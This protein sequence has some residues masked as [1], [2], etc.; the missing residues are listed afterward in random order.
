[1]LMDAFVTAVARS[2]GRFSA[3]MSNYQFRVRR[4]SEPWND[5]LLLR[6]PSLV[7][8]RT[9]AFQLIA[10]LTGQ[11]ADSP[12]L[13]SDWYV[14]VSGDDELLK[15][16]VHIITTDAPSVIGSPSLTTV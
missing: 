14:E 11:V 10:Y 12:S 15:F 2:A 7:A 8:A 16:T 5:P 3:G 4:N 13:G 9:T 1:M 6:L